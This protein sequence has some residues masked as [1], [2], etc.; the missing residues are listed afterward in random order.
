MIHLL[1]LR[2]LKILVML[3]LFNDDIDIFDA[4]SDNVISFSGDVGLANVYLNNV[5]LDHDN[6]NDN[7]PETIFIVWCN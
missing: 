2:C 1:R 6:F 4:D 5:S 7:D 3:Y